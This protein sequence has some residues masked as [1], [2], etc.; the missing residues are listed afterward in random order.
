MGDPLRLKQILINIIGNSIKFTEKGE[1]SLTV[2]PEYIKDDELTILFSVQDT[3]IGI[4]KEKIDTIFE[5]F[6]QEDSSTTRE[7]GGTGLGLDISKNLVEKMNGSI[8]VS[9]EKGKGSTFSFT[10]QFKIVDPL[11][12]AMN[13]SSLNKKR[14]LI[15]TPNSGFNDIID[16]YLTAVGMA[17]HSASSFE[18]TLSKLKNHN[19]FDIVIMDSPADRHCGFEIMKELKTNSPSAKVIL[20]VTPDK[21]NDIMAVAEKMGVTN[22]ITK[23]LSV[24]SLYEKIMKLLEDKDKTSYQNNKTVSNKQLHKKIL[25]VEDDKVSRLF[26]HKILEH[27]GYSITTATNGIEAIECFKED[28]P[29]IILMDVS[30]PVM[31]GLDATRFIRKDEE[32][33]GTRVPVIALTAFTQ[34]EDKQMCL[35]SGMDSYLTKPIDQEKLLSLLYKYTNIEP[36]KKSTDVKT[37][38]NNNTE[39]LLF[40]K[41]NTLEQTGGDSNLI[42]EVSEIFIN[43]STETLENIE[44]AINEKDFKAIERFSHFIKGRLAFFGHEGVDKSAAKLENIGRNKKIENT[45]KIYSELLNTVNSLKKELNLFLK[46]NDNESTNSR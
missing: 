26:A 33:T 13:Y 4:D 7:F 10:A 30:M 16:K 1:I 31:D 24:D 23:P 36:M 2:S 3:G 32:S 27:N 34:A 20:M 44:K 28:T 25:L 8:K 5:K 45:K 21:S 38:Q 35:D 18:D 37:V 17:S 12:S 43:E 40:N 15:L 46:E 41:K 11:T 42:K 6:S 19:H 29:D 14:A 22:F 9:S 39:Y